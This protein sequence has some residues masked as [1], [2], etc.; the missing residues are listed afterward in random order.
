MFEGQFHNKT[1]TNCVYDE[2]VLYAEKKLLL[3]VPN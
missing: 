2:T 1:G 3:N